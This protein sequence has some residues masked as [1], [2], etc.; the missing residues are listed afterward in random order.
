MLFV[1][2]GLLPGRIAFLGHLALVLPLGRQLRVF[3]GIPLVLLVAFLLHDH[4]HPVVLG[5]ARLLLVLELDLV[6][7]LLEGEGRVLLQQGLLLVLGHDGGEFLD[8]LEDQEPFVSHVQA[9]DN[10]QV[11]LVLLVVLCG[12]AVLVLHLKRLGRLLVHEGLAEGLEGPFEQLAAEEALP[13]LLE[14]EESV[15]DAA[16][17]LELL[18]GSQLLELYLGLEL[19][20]LLAAHLLDGVASLLYHVALRL[21]LD[22]RLRRL[23][24]VLVGLGLHVEVG[25]AALVEAFHR[26]VEVAPRVH[27][28]ALL[29]PLGL[30]GGG[31]DRLEDLH[32][33]AHRL[34][35]D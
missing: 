15:E 32:F 5:P 12:L 9:L 23:V 22:Q 17:L 25:A 26:L 33:F 13:G 3:L 4:L 24:R 19:V 11:I 21:H 34:L 20:Q 6:D 30:V 29:P 2:F 7:Q 18:E 28:E 1:H 16:R 8:L 10:L 31:D 27:L 35:A 14:H